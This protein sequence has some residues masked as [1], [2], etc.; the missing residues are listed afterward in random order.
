[1]TT[2]VAD[3]RAAALAA[4]ESTVPL[5]R[6][7]GLIEVAVQLAEIVS[8]AL[9]GDDDTAFAK[10]RTLPQGDITDFWDP[11]DWDLENQMPLERKALVTAHYWATWRA[12]VNWRVV[13][14]Y[15]FERELVDVR[16]VSLEATAQKL[17][18]Q[19]RA[20]HAPDS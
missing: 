7:A 4:C 8:L 17:L 20:R 1:M 6:E 5:L 12:L 9:A 2:S 15:A 19:Q 10:A 3:H 11:L 18:A 13:K 16:A 14:S